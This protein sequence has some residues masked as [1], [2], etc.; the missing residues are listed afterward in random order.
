M[1]G[2]NI[3]VIRAP[4]YR[5]LL[6]LKI[7]WSGFRKTSIVQRHLN[8]YQ[9]WAR[10]CFTCVSHSIHG[11]GAG[12]PACPLDADPHPWDA[13]LP[14]CIP[15]TNPWMQTPTPWMQ[16]PTPWMQTP[17]PGW[18]PP[19]SCDLWC[20]LGSQHPP[21]DAGHVTREAC[22]EGV[23]IWGRGLHPW[24]KADPRRTGKAGGTH[25]T[26]MLSC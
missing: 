10:Q 1:C 26:G 11:G 14:G 12:F 4:I 16:T 15:H 17:S 22:F 13:D 7:D 9:V 18:K 20:R 8:Y 19:W 24:G 6:I 23:F 25:P 5:A 21:P 3:Y 2:N